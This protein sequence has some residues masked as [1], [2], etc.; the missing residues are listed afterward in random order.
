MGKCPLDKRS[1]LFDNQIPLMRPWLEEKEWE[2]IKDVIL[3]GWVSQG[4][5]VK[6]FEDKVA[7]FVGAKYAVATNACTSAIH[8]GLRIQGVNYGDDVIVANTTC[9]ANVNAIKMAGANPVFVDIDEETYNIDPGL[10]A[11]AITNKTKAILT[12]DQIGL[13]SDLDS[14]KLVAKQHGLAIVDDA[15]TALGGKYKGAYL[16]NHDLVTTFS[17]HP[18]KMITTGEGGML[19]T[20]NI[21]IAEEARV[22]RATGASVSDL[23]RHK[24]KGI[25][26]QKY[27]DCGYN[28]R[29][30]DLQ[31]AIGIVQMGR[32]PE[33]LKERKRQ[34]DYFNQ[35]FKD[36]KNIS[37]PL[38]PEYADHAYSSYL[39]KIS[40]EVNISIEDI[41]VKMANK[42]I[43]CRYGIMPLHREPYFQ[44]KY[45][46]SMFPVSCEIAKRTFFIPI[47]PGLKDEEMEYIVDSVKE[48][49]N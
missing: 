34:A 10:I 16:G 8:L 40:K 22:L 13:A 30:T 45:N 36:V 18:R 3:S 32:L 37:I 15:A 48:I 27:Y 31:A 47:F 41:L 2:V 21:D 14:I 24:A 5:K 25:I 11:K 49:L 35:C 42:K 28:Y 17:F 9:M 6:E 4:P 26:L 39:V 7:D 12:I 33:I 44:N 19:L 1:T 43:S 23:D 38:V 20:N 29:M 46:D